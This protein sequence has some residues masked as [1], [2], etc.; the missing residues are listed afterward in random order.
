[1][2]LYWGCRSGAGPDGTAGPFPLSTDLVPSLGGP[3]VD[4]EPP[5]DSASVEAE[6]GGLA[7]DD[8]ALSPDQSDASA[9]SS[10]LLHE[11]SGSWGSEEAVVKVFDAPDADVDVDA[12]VEDDKSPGPLTGST[13][14][15]PPPGAS[16]SERREHLCGGN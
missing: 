15:R 13:D 14:I 8:C 9:D 10:E 16:G 1:M 3:A 5:F 2:L 6:G 4:R 11:I 7:T 12:D